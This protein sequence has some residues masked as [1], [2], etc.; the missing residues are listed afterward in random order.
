MSRIKEGKLKMRPKIYF[1][2][3]SV[4]AFLGLVVSVAASV[5]AVGAMSFLLR[6]SGKMFGRN[7]LE[8]LS[9]ILPWWLPLAAAA[10]LIGGIILIRRYD[11]S[12][13][14]G[15][16]KIIILIILAVLLS[17]WLVDFL[18][19]SDLLVRKGL[20][21]MRNLPEQNLR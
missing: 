17:G 9:S 2:I 11:F 5:F 8:Y 6:S 10:G 3:G 15:P 13:K 12:Y 18:G 7:K 16:K 4:L 20:M 19:V 14:M 1:V 21:R